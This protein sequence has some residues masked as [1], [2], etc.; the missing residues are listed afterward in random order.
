MS[1]LTFALEGITGVYNYGCEAIVRGTVA[2][3]RQEWPDC[4]ILYASPRR[5]SDG[6]ALEDLDVV[7]VNARREVPFVR[8]ACNKAFRLAGLPCRLKVQRYYDWLEEV[9][10][11]LSIGGDMFTLSPEAELAREF[12][13]AERTRHI[14]DSGKPLVLWG[15]SVGPFEANRR[16]VKVYSGV[17]RQMRLITARERA[18]VDYLAGLGI[19]GNVQLVSDPAFLMNVDDSHAD[20]D[21]PFFADE[22][23]VLGVNLSPLSAHFAGEADAER[24]IAKCQTEVLVRLLETGDVDVLLVPHVVC[25]WQKVDDDYSYLWDIK[26]HLGDRFG[27]RVRLLPPDIGARRTKWIISQCHALVAARMHCAI[28]GFSTGVPTL[29]LSY[30]RKAL[31][32]SDYVYGNREWVL[33]VSSGCE[34]FLAAAENLLAAAEGLRQRLGERR[35]A[36]LGDAIRAGRF[37]REVLP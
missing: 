29:L 18:T 33:P 5:E 36:I 17:L 22:R 16:A 11:V 14:M 28:A 9:D 20:E 12:P 37:L 4:R 23:P 2:I 1:G 19:K 7:L 34:P 31:G 8:R 25:P 10:C 13:A 21:G 15:A 32:M 6:K 35:K 24:G 30:S 27:S 26:E 3:L